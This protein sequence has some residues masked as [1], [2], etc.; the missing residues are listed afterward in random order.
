MVGIGNGIN[1]RADPWSARATPTMPWQVSTFD[2][3][4]LLAAWP[5]ILNRA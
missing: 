2:H 5:Q 1:A 4:Q 3:V